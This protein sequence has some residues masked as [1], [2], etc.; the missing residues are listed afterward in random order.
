MGI[1]NLG[2]EPA[3]SDLV[4]WSYRVDWGAGKAHATYP[5]DEIPPRFVAMESVMEDAAG[6]GLK[7]KIVRGPEYRGVA[8]RFSSVERLGDVDDRVG[9]DMVHLGGSIL[10]NPGRGRNRTTKR[11]AIGYVEYDGVAVDVLDMGA[12]EE[13]GL[14]VKVAGVSGIELLQ[15]QSLNVSFGFEP[16]DIPDKFLQLFTIRA[17][18]HVIPLRVHRTNSLLRRNQARRF[19]TPKSGASTSIRHCD[20]CRCT[21]T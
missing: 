9:H 11:V 15:D 14:P 8:P 4:M 18:G 1:R 17:R 19:Q 20:E 16:L 21:V 13:V 2:N 7:R 12:G 10:V 6:D 5:G 3:G